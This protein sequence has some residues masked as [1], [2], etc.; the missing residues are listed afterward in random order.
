MYNDNP[1][2]G[3]RKH[4]HVWK[5]SA[6]MT[7]AAIRQNTVT[8]KPMYWNKTFTSH[9]TDLHFTLRQSLL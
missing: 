2:L 1:Q 7:P 4:T 8:I 9:A 5:T 6:H 3:R